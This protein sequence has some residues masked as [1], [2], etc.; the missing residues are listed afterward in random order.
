[1]IR[2]ETTEFTS[3][4]AMNYER[5]MVRNDGDGA[6]CAPVLTA[7]SSSVHS[8]FRGCRITR[9]PR[10]IRALSHH[11]RRRVAV[12]SCAPS[13]DA[14]DDNPAETPVAAEAPEAA[15]STGV[16]FGRGERFPRRLVGLYE[17]ERLGID[18]SKIFE[19]NEGSQRGFAISIALVVIATF[20]VPAIS[21]YA[22]IEG[23]V[24]LII[25]AGLFVWAFDSLSL[26]GLLQGAA[27]SAL[28]SR[29]RVS[30]HEAGHFLV[31]H[32]LGVPVEGYALPSAANV[33]KGAKTGVVLEESQQVD[34]YTLAALGMSGIAAECSLFGG[35]QGGMEDLTEVNRI[36]AS[37]GGVGKRSEQDKKT[38]VR[39]GLMQALSLIKTHEAALKEL[40]G[41]LERNATVDECRKIIDQ[42]VDAAA[43]RKKGETSPLF[44]I[45][46]K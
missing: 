33:L 17:I 30:T 1:M 24:A 37:P 27:S 29:T 45:G 34:A 10:A 32:L 3:D 6:F 5:A 36:A 16:S 23:P 20:V 31:A 19:P 46:T 43:L 9:R 4:T 14:T 38:I 13:D 44:G 12:I 28:Q 2:S 18:A 8:A 39:W 15:K 40:A 42:H 25:G 35:S 11:P 26:G 22:Q 7:S 41:A 21:P